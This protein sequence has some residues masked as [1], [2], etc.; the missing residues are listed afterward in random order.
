MRGGKGRGGEGGEGIPAHNLTG[1]PEY[2]P[3]SHPEVRC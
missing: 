1:R 3:K 2:Q